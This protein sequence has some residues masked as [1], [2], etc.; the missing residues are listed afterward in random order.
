MTQVPSS[1]GGYT[2][3]S[4]PAGGTPGAGGDRT[5]ML[6]LAYLGILGLI[7]LIV[8]S[9]DRDIRWHSING[10]MLFAAYCVV[11]ILWWV[12]QGFMPDALGCALGFVGCAIFLAYLAAVVFG[13]MKALK[14][15]R[16][17]IPVLSDVAD[18]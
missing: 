7:P 4:A 17:R 3:P 11:S 18:R 16:L 10:L 5:L 15:E 6:V 14:G 1:S 9:E 13:I 12:L 2:P 8:R